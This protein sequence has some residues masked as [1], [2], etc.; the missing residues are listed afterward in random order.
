L[1]SALVTASEPCL[2]VP[3]SHLD[4]ST[5]NA[6]SSGQS[7]QEVG[8]SLRSAS[9]SGPDRAANSPEEGRT[10]E[11]LK[12]AFVPR[13]LDMGVTCRRGARS[14][15][16]GAGVVCL[17]SFN[18]HPCNLSLWRLDSHSPPLP[19]LV[20]RRI[21]HLPCLCSH[22]RTAPSCWFQ[23]AACF[24]VFDGMYV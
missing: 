11:P 23:K 9:W 24:G 7:L 13:C 2:V 1:R 21:L 19:A 5:S 10:F 4:V 12:P 22:P 20:C 18:T 3:E 16:V 14:T 17:R 6:D 8:D 15:M